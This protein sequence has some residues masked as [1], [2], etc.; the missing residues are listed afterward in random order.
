MKKMKVVPIFLV[1]ES[2]TVPLKISE[3]YYYHR[4]IYQHRGIYFPKYT[5]S[6]DW[7]NIKIIMFGEKRIKE[8]CE[9]K[10]KGKRKGKKRA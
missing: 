6:G 8:K 5:P 9:K 3:F 4:R 10:E 1:L 2:Q 7:E